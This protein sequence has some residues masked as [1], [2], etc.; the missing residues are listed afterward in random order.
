MDIELVAQN[1]LTA[2]EL[3]M[4]TEYNQGPGASSSTN[5]TVYSKLSLADSVR[6]M[7]FVKEKVQVEEGRIERFI[8]EI[9]SFA[10]VNHQNVIKLFGCCLETEAPILVY[11]F[12]SNGSL[13][14][15][16]HDRRNGENSVPYWD[17]LMEITA[18][19]AAGLSYLHSLSIIH[20]NV[21][22]SNILM[23]DC[24]AKVAGFGPLR[25]IPSNESQ[26][27]T[28]FQRTLGYLDPEYLIT[29]QLTEKSDV[30]SFGVVLVE[31]LTGEKPIDYYRP[32]SQRI[33]TSHFLLSMESQNG[34]LQIHAPQVKE[35]NKEQVTA[36]AE[37]AKRC[38]KLSSAERPTM[39]EVAGEL[40][41][42]SDTYITVHVS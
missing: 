2:E 42:M 31:I 37:L 40:K 29:G 10:Q 34:L 19:S 24:L 36:V 12:V 3:E 32:E 21:K 26:T 7:V 8:N 20:G 9:I 28:L 4:A 23:T 11:E 41:T 25:L 39:E 30:Y 16:I 38:L 6:E 27:S 33:I 22:S 18:E 5:G 1:F 35:D 15:Y 17:I 14:D 13:Y